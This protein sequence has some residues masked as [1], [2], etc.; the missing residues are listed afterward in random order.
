MASLKPGDLVRIEYSGKLASTGE[1]FEST[2]AEES[3][4]AG[5]FS[6]NKAY[7]ARLA[8]YG[9]GM[10]LPGIENAMKIA[11]QG[12]KTDFLLEA[13]DAFGTKNDDLVRVVPLEVFKAQKLVPALGMTVTVDG[14]AGTIRSTNSGRVQVDFNHPLAGR[15]VIYSLKLVEVI[16]DPKKK[17]AALFAENGIKVNVED[18]KGGL[19]IKSEGEISDALA[20]HIEILLAAA[21]PGA[22]FELGA[23]KKQ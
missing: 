22:K 6:P 1:M 15:Q 4:K 20:A 13:K 11:K 9:R 19:V 3:K 23:K 12:Q 21:V 18:G 7:G 16:T 2:S 10:M 8:I 5:I 17:I 14:V